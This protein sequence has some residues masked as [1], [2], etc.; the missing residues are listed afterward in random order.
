MVTSHV[1]CCSKA[2]FLRFSL[3]GTAAA[4]A[5]IFIVD[6]HKRS[7]VTTVNRHTEPK[8]HTTTIWAVVAYDSQ[9]FLTGAD[10]V[11]L[12]NLQ[13]HLIRKFPV[14]ATTYCL[15]VNGA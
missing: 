8:M 7:V 6:K 10:R 1:W 11:L 3:N 9:S 5:G 12:W 15:E 14:K 2:G 13:G 4:D